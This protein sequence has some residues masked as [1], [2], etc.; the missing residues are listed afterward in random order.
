MTSW[1]RY[2]AGPFGAAIAAAAAAG[3]SAFTSFSPGEIQ[4]F[5][6]SSARST[7]VTSVISEFLPA[8]ARSLGL[9]GAIAL[10]GRFGLRRVFEA[11]RSSSHCSMPCVLCAQCDRI[12]HGKQLINGAKMSWLFATMPLCRRAPRSHSL[13]VVSSGGHHRLSRCIRCNVPGHCAGHKPRNRGS[14]LWPDSRRLPGGRA[15]S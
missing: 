10:F 3:F 2:A 1:Q 15:A 5:I 13:P 7:N 4:E 14:G 8:A 11:V 12:A 9:M 6:S